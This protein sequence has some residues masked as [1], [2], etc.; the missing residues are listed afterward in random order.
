LKTLLFLMLILRLHANA[1]TAA[2]TFKP[3]SIKIHFGTGAVSDL[4]VSETAAY[5]RVGGSCPSDGHYV[6]TSAT[7]DCFRGDWLTISEDHTAGD[8]NGN[9]MIVNASYRSGHFLK[10]EISGLKAGVIYQFGVWMTNVCKPSD[11]CPFPLLPDITI[12]LHTPS[13]K[14]VAQL[15]TGELIRRLSLQWTEYTMEFTAPA[16][17]P[18][19]ILTMTDNVP[20]GCGNDFAVDDITFR[21]CVVTPPVKSPVKRTTTPK[22][23]VSAPATARKSG[24][25]T[26]S[27]KAEAPPVKP[28]AKKGTPPSKPIVKKEIRASTPVTLPSDLP[29]PSVPVVKERPPTARPAPPA[30]TGRANTV[31]KQLETEAGDLKID[32]YDNGEIDGDTVTIYHNNVLLVSRAR[33]SAQ[34]VTLRIKIDAANPHHELVMVAN[35]LGSIPPNTSLMVVTAGDKRYEVFI[36]SNEQ[37]N[38][39]VIFDLRK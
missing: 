23:A 17:E 26:A 34:P 10:T 3:P 27:T 8:V 4:N 1:Q 6:Y 25:P 12:R 20:G 19:L 2:C 24:T 13:G 5:N 33:L 21:E 9:M 15:E 28:A 30:I 22:K 32:L 29:K 36:S 14:T 18:T 11:K 37:R 39:K 38:A 16:S 7:S 35:N 31:F